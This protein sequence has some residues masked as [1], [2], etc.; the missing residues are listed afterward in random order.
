MA[1]IQNI[2]EGLSGR[3]TKFIVAAIVITFIGSIGWAGFFSQ[4]NINNI[5]KVGDKEISNAD[6][7]F[8]ISSQQFKLNQQFPDQSIEDELLLQIAT[9]SLIRKFSVLNFIENNDL[10]LSDDYV[11]RQLAKEE[12]FQENGVFSKNSFDSFARSNGFIPSDYL[13]RIKED[14]VIEFWRKGFVK[15]SFVT[16]EEVSTA[17]Y[18]AEQKRDISFFRLPVENFSQ[19]I[20]VTDDLVQEYYN[21]NVESYKTEQQ[22]KAKYINFKLDAIKDSVSIEEEDLQSEYQRYLDGFDST[23]RKLVSHIMLNTGSERSNQEALNYLEDIKIRIGKGESFED[24]VEE[25]SEDEG[26]KTSGGS[27]GVTDGTLLP[28]EFE[29]ALLSMQEGEVADPIELQNSVHLIKLTKIEL[30]QPLSFD[31]M[32]DK[33]RS[34]IVNEIA[35]GDYLDLLDKAS[36]LNFSLGDLETIAE[37]LGLSVKIT[38][39]FTIQ[40]APEALNNKKV[41]ELIFSNEDPEENF[42][43][44]IET[45]E[46]SSILFERI[47]FIAEAVIP[48]NSIKDRVTADYKETE[49]K[50]RVQEFIRKTL[51]QLN[52]NKDLKQVA[53][54][55]DVEVEAYVDLRRDSS[56]LPKSAIAE[57]FALPRAQVG[58][59]FGVS[60]AAN[61]DFLIY[62]LD[63]VNNSESTLDEEGKKEFNEYLNEQRLVAE[64]NELQLA[65]QNNTRIIR[66]N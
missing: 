17:L 60:A 33:I 1:G 15:S 26:T 55:S 14:L 9:E 39:L 45:S 38:D 31:S 11:Y 32:K 22:A 18:L 29:E 12:Q 64:L 49:S 36:E 52:N 27:L 50:V 42:N 41:L 7:S 8:E 37:E 48:Y 44:L 63:A 25:I 6:L 53:S 20:E 46:D 28:P 34:N 57:I 5:A 66:N 54:E 4:G 51:E 19:E 35:E 21:Q 13:K 65:T 40:E 10:K 24:L 58:S 16:E 56:L 61:G 43:E 30:P 47:E 23:E 62:R 59:A 3:V 2:R